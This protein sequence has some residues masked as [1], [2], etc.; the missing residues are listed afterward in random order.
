MELASR[1]EEARTSAKLLIQVVN[2]TPPSELLQNDLV[3][4]FAD[5]CQSAS[6]S[7]Q[8]YMIAEDPAPDNDTMESL[9]DVNEQLQ[10]ALNRHQRGVLSARKQLGLNSNS[11][12]H[13]SSPQLSSSQT[14]PSGPGSSNRRPQLQSY[15][16]SSSSTRAPA[17]QPHPSR[18][19]L[20]KLSKSKGKEV[21]QF[22]PPP[23][24]LTAGASSLHSNERSSGE[25]VAAE[26]PFRDPQPQSSTYYYPSGN[27]QQQASGDASVSEA[28]SSGS[29]HRASEQH[30]PGF[31][32]STTSYGARRDAAMDSVTVRGACVGQ[33]Q[34]GS[35]RSVRNDDDIYEADDLYGS[36][37]RR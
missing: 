28:G 25:G 15:P 20:P 21:E 18:E 6:R 7:V 5:R 16:S 34:G 30:R 3:K 13:L 23:E 26:D 37:H 11:P 32:D 14:P 27:T 35:S 22:V 10:S 17:P 12:A 36:S 4:E 33:G 8:V 2:N 29:Q 24:P 19:P 9:I 31:G 1:L